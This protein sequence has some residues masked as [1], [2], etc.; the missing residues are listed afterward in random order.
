MSDKRKDSLIDEELDLAH[1]IVDDLQTLVD[2][3]WD[4]DKVKLSIQ[5]LLK[6]RNKIINE[7][8]DLDEKEEKWLN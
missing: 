8:M 5:S 7:V 1:K 6:E 3:D 2:A 4:S